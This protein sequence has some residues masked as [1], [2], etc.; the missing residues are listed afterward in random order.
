MDAGYGADPLAMSVQVFNNLY[1]MLR[2][3]P[4][5]ALPAKIG[6]ILCKNKFV[7]E[8]NLCK[9]IFKRHSCCS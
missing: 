4:Q 6:N 2:T 5:E 7:K 3:A 8:E 9:C 1:D